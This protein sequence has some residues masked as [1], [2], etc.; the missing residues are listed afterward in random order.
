MFDRLLDAVFPPLCGG[1]C[2]HRGEWLCDGCV[3]SLTPAPIHTC[4]VCGARTSVWPCPLCPERPLD[5]LVA[6]V[7]LEGPARAA[8]HTLKYRD[9]PQLAQALV[10]ACL[11]LLPGLPAGAVVPVPLDGARLRERGYDQAALVAAEIGRHT[12]QR[13]IRGGLARVRAAGHQ[14][15]RSGDERRSALHAAFSWTATEVPGEGLLVDDVIT[16]GSTLVECGRA[17]RKAGAGR[18][19]GLALALG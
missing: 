6:A 19:W 18:V 9:R 12:D 7:V 11:A 3:A 4:A 1:G 8:I 16:T 10:P 14:V 5:G 17:L 13:V 15:G 2:G